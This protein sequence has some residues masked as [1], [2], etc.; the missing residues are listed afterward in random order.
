MFFLFPLAVLVTFF[1]ACLGSFLNVL[2]VR[3]REGRPPTGRSRC[4]S[5]G[6]VL[7]WKDLIPVASF[8][9]LKRRCH[10]CSQPISWQY[11]LV[12][13]GSAALFLLVFLGYVVGHLFGIPLPEASGEGALW[14]FL[15]RDLLFVVFLI[16]IFVYDFRY[17]EIPDRFTLP[18]AVIAFAVNVALGIPAASLAIGAAL[19]GCFFLAQ[20]LA[21]RGT[22]I[23][24]GDIRLGLAMG[25]M[26]GWQHGLVALFLAYVLGAIAAVTLLARGKAR[27]K[28]AVPFG[29]FLTVGTFLALLA[30]QPILEWYLGFF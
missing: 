11:P 16:P 28:T 2:V 18:A 5:C 1:G 26:L 9:L 6:V 23:G 4:S 19:L 24:G 14:V 8:F 30:G 27:M 25:A 29:T 7:R 3:T 22:W 21:S 13:A 17:G 15:A 10:S 20:Y 12:E